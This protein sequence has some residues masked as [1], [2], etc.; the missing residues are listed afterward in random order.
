M[1]TST[2]DYRRH[3]SEHKNQN[4]SSMSEILYLDV[5]KAQC[6]PVPP[7]VWTVDTVPWR[8]VT[9]HTSTSN[10]QQT[11][12]LYQPPPHQKD[13]SHMRWSVCATHLWINITEPCCNLRSPILP[14]DYKIHESRNS[15]VLY[16]HW[17]NG[18]L[19]IH[20]VKPYNL[21]SRQSHR[22]DKAG[23]GMAGSGMEG[24]I[25]YPQRKA[26]CYLNE[27]NLAL[28]SSPGAMKQG[29][30]LIQMGF[31]LQTL[32]VQNRELWLHAAIFWGFLNHFFHCTPQLHLRK[33]QGKGKSESEGSQVCPQVTH[34]KKYLTN[35]PY[36]WNH[37]SESYKKSILP[38]LGKLG[39]T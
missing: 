24:W 16:T 28:V 32:I 23:E 38:L 26:H 35:A 18:I 30:S 12:R 8:L 9:G 34:G 15:I 13:L 14:M 33:R 27:L 2:T 31:Q 37:Y 7:Y 19:T 36:T 11:V 22:E 5:T 20:G 3:K 10:S 39:P 1:K 4:Q 21:L 6:L 25:P 29:P 17:M